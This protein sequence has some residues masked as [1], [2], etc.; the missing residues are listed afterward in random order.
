MVQKISKKVGEVCKI[1]MSRKL[2][3]ANR[4]LRG[5]TAVYSSPED[6]F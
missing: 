3:R 6:W 2:G 5:Y 1:Y 4:K